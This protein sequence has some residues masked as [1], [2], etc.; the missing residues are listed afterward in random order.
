MTKRDADGNVK[1]DFLTKMKNLASK[2]PGLEDFM[3][4]EKLRE[5]DKLLREYT[6]RQLDAAKAGLD[7]VKK[8][9]LDDMKISR[10]DDVDR[11]SSK[12]DRLRDKH[13][14]DAYGYSGAFDA[15]QVLE[16]ELQKLY[17]YD[18]AILDKV[19]QFKLTCDK[20]GQEKADDQSLKIAMDSLQVEIAALAELV[21]NRGDALN[22]LVG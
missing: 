20:I 4:R 18:L 17:D 14:F 5:N 11:M 10:L 9:L 12:I 6:A 16:P 1:P 19:E 21:D 13:R 3:N 22:K 15:K 7:N 8:A 2:V